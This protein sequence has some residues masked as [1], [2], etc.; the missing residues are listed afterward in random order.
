MLSNNHKMNLA[1]SLDLLK[2]HK[3]TARKMRKHGKRKRK[4]AEEY[5]E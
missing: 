4:M 1:S 2:I 3:R 5:T